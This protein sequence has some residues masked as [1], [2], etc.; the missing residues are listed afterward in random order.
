ME[1][2]KEKVK[3]RKSLCECEA[4]I[5]LPSWPHSNSHLHVSTLHVTKIAPF[6]THLSL[7]DTHPLFPLFPSFFS[8]TLLSHIHANLAPWQA[9]PNPKPREPPPFHPPSH[10]LSSASFKNGPP[11]PLTSPAS[12]P[13]W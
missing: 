12:S 1:E 7:L 6:T 10:P 5:Y 4:V 2:N 13:S 11:T 9:R 3:K 8:Q